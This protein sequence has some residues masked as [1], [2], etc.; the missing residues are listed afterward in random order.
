L[1]LFSDNERLRKLNLLGEGSLNG[2]DLL[3]VTFDLKMTCFC[4]R[5]FSK[6]C[7]L[8]DDDRVVFEWLFRVA[9]DGVVLE[10]E[11]FFLI[12]MLL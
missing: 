9:S 3:A 8:L 7:S 10:S 6:L 1:S 5:I 2:G 4:F 12:M 11:G